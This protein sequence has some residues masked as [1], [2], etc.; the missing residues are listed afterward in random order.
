[1]WT[2]ITLLVQVMQPHTPTM[3]LTGPL[4][5]ILLVYWEIISP[6]KNLTFPANCLWSVKKLRYYFSRIMRVPDSLYDSLV[7]Y[8][9]PGLLQMFLLFHCGNFVYFWDSKLWYFISV[10]FFF[11]NFESSL[12]WQYYLVW[13][14]Y[15]NLS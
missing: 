15:V 8:V 6:K 7:F 5:T 4:Q 2:M 10:C 12:Y 11:C 1:M 13:K 14:N 3:F 9:L